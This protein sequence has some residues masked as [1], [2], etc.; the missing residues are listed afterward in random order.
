MCEFR[1]SIAGYVG[2]CR[3]C[4]DAPTRPCSD[5]SEDYV[6][7]DLAT[8]YLQ[9]DEALAI[10]HSVAA[11]GK[12]KRL[13]GKARAYGSLSVENSLVIRSSTHVHIV[14]I[15]TIHVKHVMRYATPSHQAAVGHTLT[16]C[17]VR[18]R[19]CPFITQQHRTLLLLQTNPF[20]YL[21]TNFPSTGD[22][23]SKDAVPFLW[24]LC[25]F[26][27]GRPRRNG[28]ADRKYREPQR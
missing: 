7:R 6:R 4:L 11:V 10:E 19:L 22:K 27:A 3:R 23:A 1:H 14:H 13:A 5:A 17:Q 28:P 26:R 18:R 8:R 12:S 16:Y 9:A 2:L 21:L 15:P 20:I 25:H 24:P